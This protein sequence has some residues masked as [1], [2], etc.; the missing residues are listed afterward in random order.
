MLP[1]TPG[2]ISPGCLG[3][4]SLRLFYAFYIIKSC[5]F[6][7]SFEFCK[8]TGSQIRG[9]RRLIHNSNVIF[10]KEFL[11]AQSSVMGHCRDEASMIFHPTILAFSHALTTSNTAKCLC[12]CA[13][14]WFGPWCKNSLWTNHLTSKKAINITLT[15]TSSLSLA[16]VTLDSSTQGSVAWWM[17]RARRSMTRH[18]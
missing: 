5:S 4:P 11:D 2:K 7:G 17:D 12:K 3:A 18:L 6:N 1:Y 9:V 10:G 8:V 15:W 14:W 13:V 16:L